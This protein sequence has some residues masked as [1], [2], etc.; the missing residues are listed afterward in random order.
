MISK[1]L[2][3]YDIDVCID[4]PVKQ[5]ESTEICMNIGIV[6]YLKVL[7][8]IKLENTN[9]SKIDFIWLD[10]HLEKN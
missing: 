4:S 3:E 5:I 10:G 2:K 9:S 7:S 6:K 1:Y 8:W